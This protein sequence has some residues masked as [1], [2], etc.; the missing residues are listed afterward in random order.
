MEDVV[1]NNG[2]ILIEFD[3]QSQQEIIMHPG[4]NT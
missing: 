2:P 3:G 1:V 4:K